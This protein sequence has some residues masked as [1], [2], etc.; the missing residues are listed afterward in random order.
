M[1]QPS[2]VYCLISQEPG[3]E[4]DN[5][6]QSSKSHNLFQAGLASQKTKPPIST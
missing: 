6:S 1:L 4:A 5:R 3:E 2:H